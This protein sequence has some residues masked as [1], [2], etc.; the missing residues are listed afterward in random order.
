MKSG[1]VSIIGRPN[2]GKS[3]L[4]NSI[5]ERKIAIT[6]N[7]PQTTRNNIQG[8]YHE[9][10]YQIIFVDTPGIHKPKNKLGKA[11]NDQA[12]Y[13]IND[14]DVVLLLVDVT[15]G[16]GV[17]DR[18]VIEKLKDVNKPVLLLLNKIDLI[19][20]ELILH[21]IDQYKD[22]YDFCEIIPISAL[23]GDNISVLVNIIKKHVNDP[24]KYYD[25][26]HVTDKTKEFL[27]AEYVR[28]KIL[29]LT[30]EEVPHAVTCVVENFKDNNY[31]A[32]IDVLIIVERESLKKI[33]IGKQGSMIKEI[34]TRARYDIE[35]LLQK[36]VF[37]KLY[38]KVVNNWRDRDKYLIEYGFKNNI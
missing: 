30:S 5:M 28:E 14:V 8:I 38:V 32:E 31:I 22:L 37:L 26:E 21:K 4:L 9:K 3:T 15:E 20:K 35:Q 29:N 18:F 13:C 2:V 1:F 17:G 33:I 34:G 25:D 27:I 6:S 16:L 23:K 7:K 12:Y 36:K 24:L 11:L 10:D 19:P